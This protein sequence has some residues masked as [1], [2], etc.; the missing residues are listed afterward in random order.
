MVPYSNS[1]S[2]VQLPLTSDTPSS[3]LSLET[4]IGHSFTQ[5]S[6]DFN[7]YASPHKIPDS[8]IGY[9][10]ADDYFD[11]SIDS[12]VKNRQ[13]DDYSYKSVSTQFRSENPNVSFDN[14]QTNYCAGAA[15][16]A[17][18]LILIGAAAVASTAHRAHYT[19]KQQIIGTRHSRNTGSREEESIEDSVHKE[20]EIQSPGTPRY[21]IGNEESNLK[22]KNIDGYKLSEEGEK[23][24]LGSITAPLIYDST[25]EK[26]KDYGTEDIYGNRNGESEEAKGDYEV[27]RKD[28][29]DVEED[30]TPD[31]NLANK[32]STKTNPDEVETDPDSP[33]S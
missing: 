16:L 7:L 13:A 29:E 6:I 18:I 9:R 32:E 10:H 17:F 21:S 2:A 8:L 1:T 28:M 30:K 15:L 25:R 3:K 31:K 11:T 19:P 20:K 24:L 26:T 4:T 27:K 23:T 22:V 14:S 5:P 12:L 33:D